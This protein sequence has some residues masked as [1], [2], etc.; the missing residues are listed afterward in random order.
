MMMLVNLGLVA[1]TRRLNPLGG[2]GRESDHS[3]ILSKL[4]RRHS[5]QVHDESLC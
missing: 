3:T 4:G 5:H 1:H 2:Y